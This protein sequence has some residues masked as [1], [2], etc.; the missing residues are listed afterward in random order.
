MPLSIY[1]PDDYC[2]SHPRME[3]FEHRKSRGFA[4]R[5]EEELAEVQAIEL[6]HFELPPGAHIGL[7]ELVDLIVKV[8]GKS[9]GEIFSRQKDPEVIHARRVLV[10]LMKIDGKMSWNRIMR[11]FDRT[12][13]FIT[14]AL[15]DINQAIE[16]KNQHTIRTIASIRAQYPKLE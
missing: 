16:S 15:D 9:R 5:K 8:T 11:V 6:P 1:N 4:P 2:Q 7:I 12:K 3:V 13:G 14:L 10:Y